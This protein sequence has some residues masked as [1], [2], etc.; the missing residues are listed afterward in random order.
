MINTKND[1]PS[2][3]PLDL[4]GMMTLLQ[5]SVNEYALLTSTIESELDFS[6]ISINLNQCDVDTLTIDIAPTSIA[7][8]AMA[9]VQFLNNSQPIQMQRAVE[10]H[11]DL[12]AGVDVSLIRSQL[13]DTQLI[14]HIPYTQ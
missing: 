12:P 9:S 5:P 7:I 4:K 1:T 2:I 3:L 14:L 10:K 13:T 11:I 8:R 6:V